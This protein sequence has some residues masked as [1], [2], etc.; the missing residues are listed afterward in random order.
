MSSKK[1]RITLISL[2]VILGL[3][4]G[5][6]AVVDHMKQQEEQA[7]QEEAAALRLFQFNADAVETVEITNPDG[8]FTIGT[9]NG[10]WVMKET[11]FP[12][13]FTLNAYY[14]NVIT[15]SLS[16]L[17]AEKKITADPAQSGSYG[18]DDPVTITCYAGGQSYTLQ[19]GTGSVTKEFYY[20]STG[21]SE[22]VFAIDYTAG[23]VL[24][25]GIAYL[26]DPY[27]FQFE[28]P[29]VTNFSLDRFGETAYD[30]ALDEAGQWQL[31]APVEGV[32]IDSVAVSNIMTDLVRMQYEGFEKFI[33]DESELAEYGLD[34]PAYILTLKTDDDTTVLEFPDYDPNDSVVYVYDP[35]DHAVAT[36][37]ASETA[38]LTGTW[39]QLLSE[40]LLRVPFADASRLDVTVDGKTFTLSN[41][42]GQYKLDDIEIPMTNDNLVRTF[43]NLYA[44]VSEIGFEEVDETP[45][46]PENPIPA[47]SFVYTLNDGTQR[48]L[49]LVSI[50]DKTYW[51]YVDHR[52]IGQIVRRNALSGTTGVL[53]FLEKITDA[54]ADEGIT[55]TPADAEMATEP[56][57]ETSGSGELSTEDREIVE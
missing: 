8:H 37:K 4:G 5:G 48:R 12:H 34:K 11:D 56:A 55:F 23:E 29:N 38:F 31:H 19:V 14:I 32:S 49:D 33:D 47:C 17:T 51:A 20:V 24:R 1:I 35:Q 10:A 43:E 36:I 39:S 28:E 52:C 16:D 13:D 2:L 22:D 54:L 46:A 6:Y 45:D 15:T 21:D 50:D 44:S 27:L 41:A 42:D 18:L 30:L 3:A 26:R 57:A 40:K 7:A 25:G 53:N 9:E